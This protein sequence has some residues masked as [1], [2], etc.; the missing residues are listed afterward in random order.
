MSRTWRSADVPP[1]VPIGPAGWLRVV[2]KGALL[3]LLIF[4]GLAILLLIRLIERPLCAPS[5][6]VTPQITRLV[7][8]QTLR[9]IGIGWRVRGQP[10]RGGG[11]MVA[12]HAGWLDIFALNAGMCLTFVAKAEVAD[13]PGIG[14]LA[15]ATGSL[16]IRRDPR[17]AAVQIALVGARLR[18]GQVLALFPEGT[19][20]DGLRVLPFR[21]TLFAAFLDPGL[22]G[23][24]S[25]QPVTLRWQAPAGTDPRFYGWWGDMGFC[26]HLVQVLAAPR[27][28]SVTLI[29]HAPL[30]LADF[31]DRKALARA[32]ELAVRA[33]FGAA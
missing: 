24:L 28:G 7:C 2:L 13:W 3:A 31:S 32:A 12:N 19:S 25:L 16:F 10:M 29:W 5:R 23:G 8:R 26:P 33:P 9:I 18:T 1:P 27:Q 14:W 21:A 11:A 15:R 30:R 17:Q 20:S 6:P 22:P 4:G